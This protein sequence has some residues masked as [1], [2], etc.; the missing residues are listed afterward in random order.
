MVKLDL[1]KECNRKLNLNSL[2]NG[3]MEYLADAI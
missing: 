1:K 3:F 2:L